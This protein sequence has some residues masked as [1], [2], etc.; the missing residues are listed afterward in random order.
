MPVP[1]FRRGWG[2]TPGEAELYIFNQLR[3]RADGILIP[4]LHKALLVGRNH[5]GNKYGDAWPYL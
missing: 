3:F 1:L 4:N 5:K 2:G